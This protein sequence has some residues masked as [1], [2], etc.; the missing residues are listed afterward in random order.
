METSTKMLRIGVIATG[1]ALIVG[2]KAAA[3]PKAAPAAAPESTN[4]QATPATPAGTGTGNGKEEEI[5]PR[6]LR[7]F[8]AVGGESAEAPISADKVALGRMLFHDKRL[9]RRH[10]VACNTCHLLDRFGID[11]RATSI[12]SGGQ[13]GS[14][15]APTVF[16][17]ATHIAQFWDGRSATVE[18]QAVGPIMN[19][20]E[21]AM[22]NEQAVTAVLESIPEYVTL[23]KR[24]FPDA[25][26]PVSL[27][28]VGEAIGSFVRGLT[29][30]SRWDRF[31]AGETGALTAQEKRGLKVFLDTGC[32]ACHTG[33]QVGGTMFQ[34]VGAVVPWPN[35]KDVGRVAVTKA[36]ADRMVFKVPTLKN[37]A[38]TSPYFHDGSAASL[39]EAIRLMG[40]HQLGVA[41]EHD[42]VKA[43]AAWMLSMTGDVD[44]KYV[45]APALPAS[46]QKTPRP[47]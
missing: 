37:I 44:P 43:I 29:T 28:N 2:C 26:R 13:V 1:V 5:N 35:Q 18:E 8:Q 23:F 9:S 19:P 34:K 38:K 14:R 47:L 32:M 39:E 15:N 25:A 12:G 45:A 4:V 16:N 40:H 33:P 7:R 20:K 30:K 42:E 27:K 41:L 24:A 17:A 36:P 46:T 31:I 6:L 10:D 22:P 3:L 11:G 21:M